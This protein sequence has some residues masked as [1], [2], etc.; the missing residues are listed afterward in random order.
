MGLFD[1]GYLRPGDG[2]NISN[3]YSMALNTMRPEMIGLAE[4][5]AEL[6]DDFACDI[7]S[8]GNKYGDIYEH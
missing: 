3:A 2:Q 4:Y 1:T 5:K 6:I 7:S 8:I